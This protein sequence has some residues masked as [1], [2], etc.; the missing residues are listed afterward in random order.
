MLTREQVIFWISR[1]KNGNVN[2]MAF[3]QRFIDTFVNAI[4]LYDDRIVLTYN[5]KDG[6]HNVTL[7]Q[8]EETFG[9]GDNSGSDLGERA[10]PLKNA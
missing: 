10:P 5:Y 2:D 8:V 4:Y 1:F 6:S 3:R 7:A 9:R